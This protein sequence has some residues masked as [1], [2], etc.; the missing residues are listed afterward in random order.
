MKNK[1]RN[2]ASKLPKIKQFGVIQVQDAN[3]RTNIVGVQY[4][5]GTFGV[6]DGW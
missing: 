1:S 2:Q 5:N 6:A 4:E 3:N